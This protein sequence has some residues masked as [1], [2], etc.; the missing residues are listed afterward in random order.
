M[1]NKTNWHRG[2]GR[3]KLNTQGREDDETQVK[4]LRAGQVITQEGDTQ[5]DNKR[6]LLLYFYSWSVTEMVTLILSAYLQPVVIVAIFCAA[7]LNM[8]VKHAR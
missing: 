4:Q 7:R 6:R 1:G 3:L 2:R 8:C 5:G